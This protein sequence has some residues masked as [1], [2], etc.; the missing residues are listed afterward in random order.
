MARGARTPRSNPRRWRSN[1]SASIWEGSALGITDA[2]HIESR[3]GESGS[4][5]GS[6]AWVPPGDSGMSGVGGPEASESAGDAARGFL[7]AVS[8]AC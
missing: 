6:R 8:V 7:S 4:A 1:V 3:S 2:D 5:S